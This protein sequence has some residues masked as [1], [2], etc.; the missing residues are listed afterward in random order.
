MRF[1]ALAVIN[2]VSLIVGTAIAIGGAKAGYGYWA[3]VAMTVTLPLTTTIGSGWPPA[4]FREC[5]TAE[6]EFVP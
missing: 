6:L 1:T 5:R 2:T 3:L 4:G